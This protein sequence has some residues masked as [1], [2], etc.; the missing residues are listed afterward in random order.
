MAPVRRTLEAIWMKEG[1]SVVERREGGEEL[2]IWMGPSAPSIVIV[3]VISASH[4]NADE[5]EEGMAGIEKEVG[6]LWR[7]GRREGLWLWWCVSDS[8]KGRLF[9]KWR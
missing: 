2:G 4:V 5:V 7:N 9:E 3:V 6:F 1:S 8:G